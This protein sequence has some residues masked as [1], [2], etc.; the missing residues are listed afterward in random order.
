M[1]IRDRYTVLQTAEHL[2]VQEAL[3]SEL[4]SWVALSDLQTAAAPG[5]GSI[6]KVRQGA[7]IYGTEKKFAA[8]VYDDEW[9]VSEVRGNRA[10]VSYT[11]LDV[12]KRQE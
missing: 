9:I 4:N 12:Y 8:F 2:G 3:I 6:V 10:A 11:H 5:K 1:C 7:F